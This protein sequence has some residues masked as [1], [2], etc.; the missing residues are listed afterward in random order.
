[1]RILLIT[2][3]LV[4]GG[5][6]TFVLRLARRLRQ[7]E[8]AAELLCLNPDLD[9][10][11]LVAQFDD[12]PIH[13]VPIGGLRTIKRIDR[14]G[15][16][17]GMDLQV[18]QRRAQ[19]WVE[20][21]L[22]GRFDVYHSHLF[23]ADWLLTRLKRAHPDIRIVST[24]H[25]DYALYEDRAKGTETSRVLNWGEKLAETIRS[26]DR[27]VTIS[28]A[29]HRQFVGA[30][31]VDPARLTAIP[32]GYAPPAPL[33]IPKRTT[34]G[35]LTFVMAARGMRE[36][37]WGFL[38][39]AFGNLKGDCRL[40]LVG[41]GAFLDELRAT[42]ERDPRIDFAGLH[43][44]PVEIIARCDVFVHPSIYRAESLPTVIIEALF[45]G[46]P[47]IAT[48]IGEVARMIETP[49]DDRAG[50]LVSADDTVLA[51]RLAEAM[52]VYLDDPSLRVTHGARTAAAFAKFD[53]GKCASA[54]A[55]LYAKVLEEPINSST[56][57]SH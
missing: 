36:K 15:R 18:Q 27:W 47:V 11:R 46:L 37:G 45:A 38:V 16:M 19:R 51:S 41:E 44:N 20:R 3:A 7:D 25:G 13:R 54:Y 23:G 9:D 17:I 33:P 24:L 5:A 14:V 32:N 6:E 12:I 1:M 55:A 28:K 30:F 21:H 2:D 52:Q 50:T 57:A 4:L 34:G 49:D 8:H 26:V 22:I 39:E 40:V 43:P 35:P 10:P 53:M 42:H 29:Q 31:G 48:D 56:N